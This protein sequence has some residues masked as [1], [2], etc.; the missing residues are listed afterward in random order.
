MSSPQFYCTPRRTARFGR[1]LAL[2][3]ATIASATCAVAIGLLSWQELH[4]HSPAA[5]SALAIAILLTGFL[6]A[7]L[8]WHLYH[9]AERRN[10]AWS[11]CLWFARWSFVSLFSAYVLTLAIHPAEAL[12]LFGWAALF[13]ATLGLLPLL[14]DRQTQ[15]LCRLAARQRPLRRLGRFSFRMFLTAVLAE[16]GLAAYDGLCGGLSGA[17]IELSPGS[18]LLALAESDTPDHDPPRTAFHVAVVGGGT[19]EAGGA[20]PRFEAQLEAL[21]PASSVQPIAFASAAGPRSPQELQAAVFA[22]HP[23]L[24]LW[25]V[26]AADWLTLDPPARD[27]FAWRSLRLARFLLPNAVESESTSSR[28]AAAQPPCAAEPNFSLAREA[29]LSACERRLEAYR[30]PLS[31]AM[32]QR[33]ARLESSLAQ[34]AAAATKHNIPFVIVLQPSDLQLNSDL[35]TAVR[36]RLGWQTDEVDP[37]L[38]Q[39]RL[40]AFTAAHGIP[41]YDLA[42]ALANSEANS[43]AESSPA[44]SP[45]GNELAAIGLGR[46]LNARY[47]AMIASAAQ[48][49]LR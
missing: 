42:P 29:Y 23:D 31:A 37:E 14:E 9:A 12:L 20:A 47:G 38:P 22:A 28:S 11:H 41:T 1:S 36:Q 5:R 34:L 32:R 2:L 15:W 43:F 3:L 8:A 49:K 6:Q 7:F 17:A 26:P 16:A 46:W 24:V 45:A 39:R 13:L 19:L 33:W 4:P 27:P 44:L 21:I 48:A 10:L 40:L 18:S 25:C 30:A 35:R